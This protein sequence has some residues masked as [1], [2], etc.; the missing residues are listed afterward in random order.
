MDR[1]LERIGCPALN[2][3]QYSKHSKPGWQVNAV[4]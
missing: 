4:D 1:I 3:G 2:G